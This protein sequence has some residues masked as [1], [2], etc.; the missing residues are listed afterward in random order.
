MHSFPVCHCWWKCCI[1]L[2]WGR[3]W[4]SNNEQSVAECARALC[5]R[6]LSTVYALQYCMTFWPPKQG[7]VYTLLYCM[8]FRPS[9]YGILRVYKAWV[10]AYCTVFHLISTGCQCRSKNVRTKI[11]LGVMKVEWLTFIVIIIMLLWQRHKPKTSRAIM[12][13]LY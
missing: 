11:K 3:G 9:L 12:M 7:A 13:L 5:I 8:T 1:V 6:T 10:F 4:F 2:L